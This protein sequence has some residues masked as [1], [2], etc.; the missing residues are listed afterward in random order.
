MNGWI[1]PVDKAEHN[2]FEVIYYFGNGNIMQIVKLT[3]R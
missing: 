2:K 1:L 3:L